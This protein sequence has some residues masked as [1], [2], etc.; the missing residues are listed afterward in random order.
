MATQRFTVPRDIYFGKGALSQLGGLE[1]ERAM[2]VLGGEAMRRYGFADKAESWLKKAGMQVDRFEDVEP[3]PTLE[4]VR[5]GAKAMAAFQ[6]D[7]IVALG[8]GSPIDAAKAMWIF[9]EHPELTFDAIKNPFTLPAL[10][11]KARFAAVPSTSGTATEVTAFSVITDDDTHVKY[12]LADYALTPDVAIVD[13]DLAMTMPPEL[14]A[15]TGMDAL[16]HAI[17]AYVSKGANAFT[18]PLALRAIEMIH[19]Q[20]LQSYKEGDDG[21]REQM[22]YA[23]CLAGIAFSNAGLGISHALAHATGARLGIPHG[24]AN[25]IYLPYVIRFNQKACAQRYAQIAQRLCLKGDS[26][27]RLTDSLC[28]A[29]TAFNNVLDLPTSLRKAGVDERRF[30]AVADEAALSAAEDACAK[31]NP[32]RAGEHELKAILMEAYDGSREK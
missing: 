17:E 27:D 6:P 1:G 24:L 23:Q 25:A 3:D 21:A 10:R 26:A 15:R 18:D 30:A 20:L 28:E 29:V 9:Y 4:T 8:G 12:P 19:A 11:R 5:R 32:R 22:H 2:L 7:W 13:P 16:T 14:T 31:T